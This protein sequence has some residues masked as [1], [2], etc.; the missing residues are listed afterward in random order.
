[1]I[2]I[3]QKFSGEHEFL[4]NFSP[5]GFKL[6][7]IWFPTNEHF[8]QAMKCKVGD[9][10]SFREIV[11]APTPGK[12]KRIARKVPLR[13]NWDEIKIQ[14]MSDGLGFKFEQNPD[15]RQKLLDTGEAMLIEGNNWHDNFWGDCKC[16]KCILKMGRNLLGV[17]LMF[18]RG[19]IRQEQ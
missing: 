18:L 12:A 11:D 17:S 1:M 13:E 3:I 14:I 15:I 10:K 16:E 9:L 2:E 8:F 7:D 4:S 5:H 6:Q 19:R